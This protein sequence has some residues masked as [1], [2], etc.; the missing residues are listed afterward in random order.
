MPTEQ[1]EQCLPS[2]G[3]WG[4]RIWLGTKVLQESVLHHWGF[5]VGCTLSLRRGRGQ[6]ARHGG[7]A[8]VKAE[9]VQGNET[10]SLGWVES[11]R[12]GLPGRP[13]KE[14]GLFQTLLHRS[15]RTPKPNLS[16][17]WSQLENSPD[18]RESLLVRQF[19]LAV[20]AQST[21]QP[22]SPLP[23][24]PPLPL[25]HSAAVWGGWGHLLPSSR[26]KPS[27]GSRC[28]AHA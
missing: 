4:C 23:Q 17:Q 3:G 11:Q 6:M 8:L 19:L 9:F 20:E 1:E 18:L 26:G 27:S 12:E 24:L 28:A 7:S 22:L 25:Q 21:R 15:P 13:A 5:G 16:L 14:Q 2:A 10:N